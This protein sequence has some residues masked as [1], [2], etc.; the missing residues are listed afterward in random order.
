[1]N[2]VALVESNLKNLKQANQL[3]V[4]IDFTKTADR[5]WCVVSDQKEDS[6]NLISEKIFTGHSIS[7]EISLL[8]AL[9]E[10]VE[11][12][13]FVGGHQKGLASCQTERSDGFAAFPMIHDVA[14]DKA[15][16]NAFAEAV[17]R[18][19]WATWW[20]NDHIQFDLKTLS[21]LDSKYLD[22]LFSELDLEEVFLITPKIKNCDHEVQIVFAKIKNKGYLSGGACGL[23]QKQETL[24]KALDELLRHGLAFMKALKENR[25]PESFYEERLYFFASGQGNYLVENKLQ[26]KG[27]KPIILPKLQIDSEVPTAF[28]NYKV[29]RCLFE[30]QPPFVGGEVK[31][32]CL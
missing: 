28:L 11:R 15:R 3:P 10:R 27:T 30:N 18:F 6:Y 23:N 9:S 20:D 25:K 21:K 29:H 13:A 7:K 16:E 12:L 17:E 31:R 14:V 26:Q 24:D 8:K 2:E 4:R 5:Y 22:Y 19:A 32:L 1:M